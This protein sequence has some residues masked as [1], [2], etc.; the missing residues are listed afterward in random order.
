M[1]AKL[2]HLVTWHNRS[3]YWFWPRLL[4]SWRGRSRGR[5]SRWHWSWRHWSR[6]HRSWR[7]WSCR[8]RSQ[9][10]LSSGGIS[11]RFLYC[12]L[13]PPLTWVSSSAWFTGRSRGFNLILFSSFWG[14]QAQ[15][16]GLRYPPKTLT[17]VS[18]SSFIGTLGPWK[19]HIL[20]N[21]YSSIIDHLIM[22]GQIWPPFLLELVVLLCPKPNAG[23]DKRDEDDED[24]YRYPDDQTQATI[25]FN[26]VTLRKLNVTFEKSEIS[27]NISCFPD[28]PHHHHHVTATNFW[29]LAR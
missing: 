18:L 20:H 26:V 14:S 17:L 21:K 10:L 3:S 9:R 16:Q 24:N 13:Q 5:W 11:P 1:I 6:W 23:H 25:L 15:L 12:P 29:R 28:D 8:H 27:K 7:H 4:W 22:R 2:S 19:K